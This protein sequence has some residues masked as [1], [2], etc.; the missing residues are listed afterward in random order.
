MFPARRE[1][2]SEAAVA[3]LRENVGEL[4]LCVLYLLD[5]DQRVASLPGSIRLAPVL[6]PARPASMLRGRNSLDR[7]L[8]RD[9]K[10]GLANPVALVASNGT[11]AAV[12]ILTACEAALVRFPLKMWFDRICSTRIRQISDF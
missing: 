7:E 6:R 5:P 3:V 2:A 4:A 10:V 12:M 1:E 9:R 8:T 11:S